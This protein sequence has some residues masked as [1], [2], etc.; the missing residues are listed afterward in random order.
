MPL[1]SWAPRWPLAAASRREITEAALTS[2]SAR[3]T[4]MPS[5]NPPPSPNPFPSAGFPCCPPTTNPPSVQTLIDLSDDG[6]IGSRCSLQTHNSLSYTP[7][8]SSL[9][10]FWKPALAEKSLPPPSIVDCFTFCYPSA[11]SLS[12][13]S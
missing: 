12:A 10:P 11:F 6:F 13:S 8:S 9:I 7:S 3:A 4:V 1:L 5:P 2:L